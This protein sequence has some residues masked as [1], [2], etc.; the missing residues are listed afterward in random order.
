MN[1][2][3]RSIVRHAERTTGLEIAWLPAHNVL[4]GSE[5]GKPVVSSEVGSSVRHACL[6]LRE[7][8]LA[9]IR[10]E[11]M[12]EQKGLCVNCNGRRLEMHHK[13]HRSQGGTDARDNL[14]L[15]CV[16]CHRRKHGG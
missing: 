8:N 3:E 4:V 11:M 2:S 10:D 6:R 9:R 15:I 13:T 12:R 16:D 7:K 14:E 5:G 1:E